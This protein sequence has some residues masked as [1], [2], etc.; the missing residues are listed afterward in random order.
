MINDER[1]AVGKDA[2]PTMFHYLLEMHKNGRPLLKLEM[3]V[4]VEAFP[5]VHMNLLSSMEAMLVRYGAAQGAL[6]DGREHRENHER[7]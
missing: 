1:L 6:L 2:P 5:T 7:S 4:P 3:N